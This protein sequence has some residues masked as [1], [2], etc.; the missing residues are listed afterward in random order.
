VLSASFDQECVNDTK[1]RTP[2]IAGTVTPQRNA[3]VNL[4]MTPVV[5]SRGFQELGSESES[6]LTLKSQRQL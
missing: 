4:H 3:S 1:R 6:H 5:L 2:F